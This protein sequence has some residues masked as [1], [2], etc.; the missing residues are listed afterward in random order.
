MTTSTTFHCALLSEQRAAED[1]HGS[2]IAD[3]RCELDNSQ[4]HQATLAV[5][6]RLD[7]QG[8]KR[9]DVVAVLLPNGIEL[10]VTMFAT[11]YLGATLTPINPALTSGEIDYQLE[12]SHAQVLVTNDQPEHRPARA[13]PRI[14]T[15]GPDFLEEVPATLP[16]CRPEPGDL[17]LLI[18]T[19]GTTGRPKGVMLDHANV[20]A[21]TSS[22]IEHFALTPADR[23]LLVLPL[24]H[25]NGLIVG[26]ISVLRARG[27]VAIIPR[28]EASTFWDAVAAFRPTYFSAVPTIY[29]TLEALPAKVSPDIS[30]LRFGICGAAPMPAELIGRFEARYGVP[31]VEG[32]GLSEGTV[33][34]VINPVYGPRKPG[35]V[36]VTLP[37]HTVWVVDD[38][39]QRAPVGTAGEVVLTGPTVMRGYLE[40]PE[41]T[42]A[43]L[44]EGWLHTGDIG[45]FDADGYLTL[46]DRVTDIII[47][48]GENIYPKEI[49]EVLY[50]HPAVLDA[51][52]VGAPDPVLGE[53]PIAFI[54]LH[55]DRPCD[56]SALVEYCRTK[57]ARY[58]IPK[59][60]NVR[61]Q[62]PKNA[63]GKI[64]KGQL[65]EELR[66]GL[67]T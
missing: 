19:S 27:D 18:Y 39:G 34:S 17:A 46:V 31:I 12:D 9:G 15:I 33:A 49:E 35:T 41:D 4:F 59:V 13:S 3:A 50:R 60:V 64:T 67:P 48:G 36:G 25:A 20:I 66:A 21:M 6:T 47:R 40:R 42:A 14:L 52:V 24:F 16:A 63:V 37:G 32:Y 44:R 22:L 5:A 29:A 54:A 58:K 62:L 11:W 2:F 61:E 65:R 53:V 1:P 51:A 10:I 28:F 43:A 55:P 38:R 7:A 57:L 56:P 45:F 26:V 30:S 8:I 23:S